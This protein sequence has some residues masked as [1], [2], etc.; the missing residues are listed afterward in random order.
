MLTTEGK[1]HEPF[2]SIIMP[3]YNSEKYVDNA[4][5]S[6]IGQTYDNWELIAINDGS[7]DRTP[8]ILN[9]YAEKDARIKVLSKDN[10]GYCSAVNMGLD[11]VCGTYFLF[12]GS[13]DGLLESALESIF[14]KASTNITTPPDLIA[15]RTIECINKIPSGVDK[16][17]DFDSFEYDCETDIKEYEKKHP[18]H[19]KIFTIRDTSKCYKTELLGNLR[20]FGKYGFDADGIF[21]M[22][23]SYKCRSFMNIPV[24]GYI[25]N[26]REDSLSRRKLT[27]EVYKD[28]LDN[29]KL[30]YSEIK[31]IKPEKITDQTKYYLDYYYDL[32]WKYATMIKNRNRRDFKFLKQH[33]RFIFSLMRKY[34][35]SIG[36]S[37]SERFSNYL[38]LLFPNI[39]KNIFETRRDYHNAK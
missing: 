17:S 35:I 12:M 32:A 38:Y 26:K 9:N 24:D 23:F 10:G 33:T 14:K 8:E 39:N 25:W 19:A 5:Q 3:C 21:S 34:R 20:Y 37:F 18:K 2:F 27:N 31:K 1:K 7:T 6:I 29:W 13:D 36:N 11:Y 16:Y 15:F 28:R 30:F 22:L 4:V